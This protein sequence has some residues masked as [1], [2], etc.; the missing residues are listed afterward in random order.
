MQEEEEKTRKLSEVT[1]ISD[2]SCSPPFT[3]GLLCPQGGGG[4][5][6]RPEDR[7]GGE[8]GQHQAD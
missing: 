7:E 6:A 3:P 5:G 8:E 2:I 4:Q 1:Q